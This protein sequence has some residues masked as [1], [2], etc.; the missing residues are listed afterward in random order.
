M[1]LNQD[2]ASV[3]VNVVT[4]GNTEG[5]G[6]FDWQLRSEVKYQC[7]QDHFFFSKTDLKQHAFDSDDICRN[8]NMGGAS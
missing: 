3:L 4:V 6:V 1:S 5:R 2:S 7:H 8:E